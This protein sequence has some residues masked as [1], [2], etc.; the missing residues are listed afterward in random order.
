MR[1][2]CYTE[3]VVSETYTHNS[4]SFYLSEEVVIISQYAFDEFE[5][6]G[7]VQKVEFEEMR[8][9]RIGQ[10]AQVFEHRESISCRGTQRLGISI[11]QGDFGQLLGVEVSSFVLVYHLIYN[12]HDQLSKGGC[13]GRRDDCDPGFL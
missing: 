10:K 11:R 1:S 6:K 13:G 3:K 5:S 12:K 8:P 4:K 2:G 9:L 7:F